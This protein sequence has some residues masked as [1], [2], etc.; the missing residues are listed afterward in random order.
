MAIYKTKDIDNTYVYQASI[1]IRNTEHL[2]GK[3]TARNIEA[4]KIKKMIKQEYR[5]SKKLTD[6]LIISPRSL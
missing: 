5:N 4:T 1:R 6:L 2:Q 3:V